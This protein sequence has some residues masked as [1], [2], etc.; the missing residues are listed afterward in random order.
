VV[1]APERI[2]ST[3]DKSTIRN[4]SFNQS[5]TST[6]IL[7]QCNKFFLTNLLDES[8]YNKSDRIQGEDKQK[9][10]IEFDKDEASSNKGKHSMQAKQQWKFL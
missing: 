7:F 8:S 9:G 10:V 2:G 5:I 3:P 1:L 4:S 6:P